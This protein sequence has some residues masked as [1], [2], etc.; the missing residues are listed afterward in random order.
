MD[1]A[2]PSKELT[3]VMG[4][5]HSHKNGEIR[6]LLLTEISDHMVKLSQS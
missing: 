2:S 4:Y 3:C 1:Q 6:C 5:Q